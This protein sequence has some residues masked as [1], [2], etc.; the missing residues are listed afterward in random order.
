MN[1]E[2]IE[3]L[4]VI[5]EE[6]QRILAGQKNINKTIYTKKKELV[7]ESEHFLQKGK[8]IQVRPH[9][10]FVHFPKHITDIYIYS[11]IVPSVHFFPVFRKSSVMTC[12][13]IRSAFV[14]WL[15]V[16]INVNCE[17]VKVRPS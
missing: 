13:V 8:L 4:S 9:T 12:Q 17:I 14:V 3:K 7:V 10:R 5:T 2:I 1:A 15:V 16:I 11:S 6:E